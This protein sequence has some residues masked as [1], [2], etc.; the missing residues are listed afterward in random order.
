MERVTRASGTR[1][2]E[3]VCMTQQALIGTP[4]VLALVIWRPTPGLYE[5][6]YYGRKYFS[7]RD[8]V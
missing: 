6:W 1:P 4:S 8:N 3:N 2:S 7:F 5:H